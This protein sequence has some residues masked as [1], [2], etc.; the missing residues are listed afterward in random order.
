MAKNITFLEENIKVEQPNMWLAHNERLNLY[1]HRNFKMIDRMKK[2]GINE[3]QPRVTKVEGDYVYSE[4]F[5]QITSIDDKGDYWYIGHK[6]VGKHS[7][8][9]GFG[10]TRLY[11][12]RIPQYGTIAFEDATNIDIR[13]GL[14]KEA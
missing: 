1:I 10:Y 5:V 14:A 13:T 8:S 2:N 9:Y 11:K 4:T 6:P 7:G 12:D 3:I